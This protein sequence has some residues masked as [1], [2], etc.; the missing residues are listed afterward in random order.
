MT[1]KIK[2]SYDFALKQENLN[3]YHLTNE[4]PLILI[5]TQIFSLS[6]VNKNDYCAKKPFKI[7][8]DSLVRTTVL[9]DNNLFSNRTSEESALAI[10]STYIIALESFIAEN[11]FVKPLFF[12]KCFGHFT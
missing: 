9:I 4:V 5:P 11:S 10:A 8:K 6:T 12:K 1:L 2:E 7:G 3:R